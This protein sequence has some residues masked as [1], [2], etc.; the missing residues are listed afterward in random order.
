MVSIIAYVLPALMILWSRPSV[1]ADLTDVSGGILAA[2]GF[3]V[4]S[5]RA[6]SPTT[7]VGASG[8]CH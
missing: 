5:T 8:R 3:L 4:S 1:G 7:R 6:S 2:P